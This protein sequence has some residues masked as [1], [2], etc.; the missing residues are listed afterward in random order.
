MKEGNQRM[1]DE[2][3]ERAGERERGGKSLSNLKSQISN[4]KKVLPLSRS[5]ALPLFLH[6]SSFI[7]SYA[8]AAFNNR[9][10]SK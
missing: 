6:P 4:L 7:L 10:S 1:K 2:G 3:E 5:P 8:Y 9:A